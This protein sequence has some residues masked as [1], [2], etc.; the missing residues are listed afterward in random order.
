MRESE[1]QEV[2]RDV[3]GGSI[4]VAHSVLIA[5]DARTMSTWMHRLAVLFL[6][7]IASWSCSSAHVERPPWTTIV[8]PDG[9]PAAFLYAD[10]IVNGR[11][12]RVERGLFTSD[13]Y[14]FFYDTFE[15]GSFFVVDNRSYRPFVLESFDAVS[16][17]RLW[18]INH[19]LTGR[20]PTPTMWGASAY[21]HANCI[22][23][24]STP[25]DFVLA[26][27]T[28]EIIRFRNDGGDMPAGFRGWLISTLPACLRQGPGFML[29]QFGAESISEPW[30]KGRVCF[31]GA[32]NEEAQPCRALPTARLPGHVS[33]QQFTF[34][35]ANGSVIFGGNNGILEIPY[36]PAC[37]TREGEGCDADP[38]PEA[39]VLSP[40][41]P[42]PYTQ[43]DVSNNGA[44]LAVVSLGAAACPDGA[45][46][47]VVDLDRRRRGWTCVDT[48][49]NTVRISD[50]GRVSAYNRLSVVWVRQ[51]SDFRW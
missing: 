33:W 51:G 26:P 48:Q 45:L 9:T 2:R 30:I 43:R 13:P 27:R 14:N 17:R 6:M 32:E 21:T 34:A 4:A 37:F 25:Y 8:T 19:T 42:A 29:A 39:R 11:G 24:P 3:L 15:D 35:R 5:L 22:V 18:H 41:P 23:L 47:E 38:R 28:G 1:I 40:A 10:G 16:L 20:I 31:H 44:W 36:P 46:L 12:D 50:A 7:A 49:F